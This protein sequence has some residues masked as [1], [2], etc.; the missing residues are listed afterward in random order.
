MGYN[1]WVVWAVALWGLPFWII[2]CDLTMSGPGWDLP[3]TGWGRPRAVPVSQ[4]ALRSVF[5][6]YVKKNRNWKL[7]TTTFVLWRSRIPDTDPRIFSSRIQRVKKHRIPDPNSQHCSQQTRDK[8]YSSSF[9]DP[10]CLFRITEPDPKI[11]CCVLY[12]YRH[13]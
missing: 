7:Q 5:L 8:N 13:R 12:V 4:H 10:E 11:F 9:A 3:T 2:T 1:R 6:C